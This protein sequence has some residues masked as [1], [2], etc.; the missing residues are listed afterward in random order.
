MVFIRQINGKQTAAAHR[1]ESEQQRRSDGRGLPL[2]ECRDTGKE[3]D[4]QAAC[5]RDDT[6][7]RF[8]DRLLQRERWIISFVMASCVSASNIAWALGFMSH[9]QLSK[10]SKKGISGNYGILDQIMALQWIHD[11]IASFGGDPDKVTIAGESAGGISVSIL[12]ASP[13]CKGLFRSRNQ[14][15]RQFILACC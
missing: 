9:P 11:N 5:L 1:L 12:C 7:R 13:L 4:R 6:W 2:S 15:K 10:E 3:H 8:S 14:R